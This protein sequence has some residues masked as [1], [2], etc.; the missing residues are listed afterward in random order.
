MRFGSAEEAMAQEADQRDSLRKLQAL[1][2]HVQVA[3][4]T[5]ISLDGSLRSRPMVTQDPKVEFDGALW[6]FTEASSDKVRE[7]QAR[8]EVNLSY[9]NGNNT[10][11]SVSGRAE[12]VRDRHWMEELWSPSV[13]AWFPE[14]L[15]DPDI[16]L[17]KVTVE[18]AEYWDTPNSKIVQTLAFT[19]AILSGQR[20]EGSE[21]G[22]VSLGGSAGEGGKTPDAELPSDR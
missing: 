5:T 11:V 7:I 15:D 2:E 4:L 18:K 6:F 16:A 14:G 3:M 19:K 1:I 13:T 9:S 17:L 22:K 21:H 20:F 8:A 12:L 10:Y